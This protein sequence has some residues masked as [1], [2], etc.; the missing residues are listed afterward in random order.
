MQGNYE[1]GWYDHPSLGLIKVYP[2][3]GSGW[4]YRCYTQRGDK[5]LSK[6]RPLDQ[7]T[8]ALSEKRPDG[9]LLG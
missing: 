7:W 2:S 6:E 4:V 9:D 5:A 8:W 1:S 3:S